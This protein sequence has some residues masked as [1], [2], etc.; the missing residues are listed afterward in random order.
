MDAVA[1]VIVLLIVF[2]LVFSTGSGKTLKCEK[3]GFCTDDPL[4][5]E[6]HKVTENAHKFKEV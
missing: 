2:A 6:G 4:R 1:L 5:A 3:C